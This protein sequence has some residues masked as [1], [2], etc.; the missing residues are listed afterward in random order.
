MTTAHALRLLSDTSSVTRDQRAA[1][2][3]AADQLDAAAERSKLAVQALEE[4]RAII[5]VWHGMRP[6]PI[7]EAGMP[8]GP[9]APSIN[10]D[11]MRAELTWELYQKSP[12]MRRL[13]AAIKRLKGG[14]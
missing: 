11:A 2:R 1:L 4:A 8:T 9:A 6:R 13:D 12:E 7:Y 5:Q 10:T 14:L 3:I